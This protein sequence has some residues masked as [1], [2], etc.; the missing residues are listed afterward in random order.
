LAWQAT[1]VQQPVVDIRLLNSVFLYDQI[2]SATTEFLDFMDPLQGKILGAARQNIDYIGAIDPASYN[3]GPANIRGTTWA[4]GRIG[5]VWWNTSTVRF[6][7]PNQ[8]NIV[9][10]SRRWAQLFPGSSVDVYQW[11]ESDVPPANYA[12]EGTVFS[13]LRYTVNSSLSF[14]GTIVTRYYFWVRGITVTSSKLNKTLPVSTVASYIE[15]PRASGIPYLAPINSSTVAL[16]N[17]GDFIVASD[18]VLHIEFDRELTTDNVHVEYELI[19][20]DRA[21][22]FLSNNLYRKLQDSF[23]GVDTFGNQ[24]PDLGLSP[25]ERYGVQ[26]RPRQSMFVDRFEALRNYLTR[27]NA[28]LRQYTITE[29]RIF[30][31]LNSSEPEPSA[32]SGLWNLRVTNLEIL[33]FQNIYAVPLGYKYLVETDS[34]NRGLWTIY[35]VQLSETQAG[36][37]ETVL[38]R[39]QNFN[40]PDYW[41]YIDWYRPGYNTSSKITTEVSSFSQLDTLSV[42]VG[43]SVKVTA[44]AQGKFEIY[45]RTELSWDRVG[46]QDGTI[47]FSAELWDYALGRFG[48]DL[49]VFD[50]QYYDQEPVIETRKIIQAI[51]QE[52]FIDDLA[53]ERN[54]ALVLMFNYVLS[55]FSAPEWLVKTSL[56]DV[57]HRI[58]DLV[59]YQNYI[60]DNQ[61][62]VED[63]IQEVKPYH[64][65]IREFN[66][67]YAGFDDFR[68]DV[69]DFDV[70]AYFNTTLEIP[71]YTSPVLLPY[72]LGTAFNAQ[73]TT[74]SD[75]PASSTVW[76]S[77]P[78]SA[79]FQNYLLNIIDIQI[80]NGGSGYNE[81]P[82]VTFVGSAVQ[83]AQGRATINSVGQV[84]G[85][86]I[87][88]PGVGYRATPQIVFSG[89][90]G[91]NARAYAV[92]G[93]AV[94]QNYSQSVVPAGSVAYSPVRTFRTTMKF[95]RYQ[96]VPSLSEWNANAIY[97]NGDLVRYDN[98][99][100]QAASTDS[101]AVVGPT[102][103]LENWQL[104]NAGTYNNG[105]GLSGVDRT[106]GLYVAGVNSPG[107]ELPLLIDGVDYPGVQVYG[108]YFLG[109]TNAIDAEYQSKFTDT[110]LG[111]RFSDINVDGGEFIGPYE[112]HAPE[113]LING[114]EFD[115]LD[116]RV[117][118]R[119]GSDW[120]GD[121]HGFEIGTV[122]FTYE[123]AIATTYSWANVVENPVQILASNLTTGIDLNRDIDY[124]LNWSNQTITLLANAVAGDIIN[125]SVYEAGGGSQLYRA[126]Y[127]GVDVGPTVVIPVNNAEIYDVAVFV[128]GQLI[129][130]VT[131]VPYAE[132]ATWNVL[133][134]YQKLTVVVD[135]GNYYRALQTV[136]VGTS[137]TDAAY[138]L[139]FVPTLE[140]QVTFGQTFGFD[141]GVA[142][143]ALGITTPEQY[144]WSTPQVQTV[145]A[146]AATVL[147]KT[148]TL[149]N[150]LEGTNPA[151]MIVTRNGLRLQPAEGIEW[152]GDDSS[153]SFG[154][155]QRGGY[156][157][158]II[159]PATDVLVWVDNVLQ[160]QS[161]GAFVGDFSVTNW[162]GSNTPGRQV[163]FTTPPAAGAQILIS[164]NTIADYIVAGNQIQIASTVNLGDVLAITTWNDTAQQNI[165]TQVFVGP[166]ESG[167]VI[168][169]PYDS[170]DYDP[171]VIN[172]TPGSY[173][174]T[175]GTSVANNQFDLQRTDIVASRLWVTLDGYRLFEG[176]DY[177]VENGFLILASGAIGP[178]QVLA[179]TQ[180]TNSIT[181]EEMGFRIFQDMRGVQATYRITR[182][183]TTQVAIAVT[184]DADEIFVAD[185]TALSE[186]NLDLGIF[187]AVIIDG[188]R[189]MYRV[190]DLSLNKISSLL[191]GTA[192]TGAAPHAAGTDVTDLG[193]GNLLDQR[194]QNYVV[195]DT[196][197]S[198]GSSS[199]YYAPSIDIDSA[200]QD[201]S[202][203]I[204]ALEVYVG[205]VRQ[206]AYSDTVATSQYRWIVTDFDPVAV[207]F[208]TDSDPVDPL[209]LPPAGVEVTILVRRGVTW[210]A[211]GVDS[212]SNGVALQDTNTEAARF[213]RG[214]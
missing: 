52:L 95:D 192:G 58:R 144:L 125:I 33:G 45:L 8:D 138:W 10:A 166:V 81:P 140:T 60:R 56:I 63:Y 158:S 93:S 111:N 3:A 143:L 7:D 193:R 35:T 174:F 194:Y 99:V 85:V 107:L 186:P 88:T 113:E 203:D 213:L 126:N 154:L 105:V 82:L 120:S 17:S 116:F 145:V 121:G 72:T 98:R 75:L 94:S 161:L 34:R 42:P 207:E 200:Y 48:F 59:P 124:T 5:E 73:L 195:S 47:E 100:W 214:L 23:C 19:A 156:Q 53:I 104:V 77:W 196:T 57:D 76:T 117:F 89:G 70:P 212:A 112:G 135:T 164:V 177:T 21:D 106:M 189:I 103:D 136:P 210:Y 4:A 153:V 102:F 141:D 92:M 101:T 28:V 1:T 66:L 9:Y 108:E 163:V 78:Y 39:V 80:I 199:V 16:Y 22:G 29:S 65:Q 69:V 14:D 209:L 51:N 132:A 68:G 146:N 38:T 15:S 129:D 155:P 147:T 110:A 165:L 61:E 96:Y 201:S 119:P 36:I 43:S 167:V 160:T 171:A 41:N 162:P 185:A 2:T 187:G 205:G 142:L 204:L 148:I 168:N 179:V 159:D 211:P 90:N 62:F 149:I 30:N 133:N 182:S 188:E 24:V 18:T 114:S 71:E 74:Q 26:F 183:T 170:T 11:I 55:E 86:V 127:I 173:D 118:T 130:T 137:L 40:T 83:P 37:R 134:S 20:Q 198:D 46:L 97:Q 49:E 87:T 152:I 50:A 206:Y 191:R 122:R 91:I 84:S 175:T 44:N 178:A 169:E 139:A 208:L 150:S 202:S 197:L 184:A 64:V 25:A 32:S 181:P 123:P 109:N 6:I 190:R 27:A 180:F 157:Q 54:R 13:T 12:G 128:N 131:W 67:K 115:T 79:W 151:N 172:D 176:A 31:L